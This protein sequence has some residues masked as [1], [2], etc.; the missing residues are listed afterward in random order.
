MD[1]SDI[2]I[3][4]VD[5]EPDILE[6]VEYNLKTEGYQV[7]TANNGA[8]GVKKANEKSY[9]LI[10]MDIRMPVM[11]GLDATA[12]IRS[13]DGPNKSAPIV[14]LSAHTA[15]SQIDQVQSSGMSGFFSKP[16]RLSDLT[17][18]LSNPAWADPKTFSQSHQAMSDIQKVLGSE[19]SAQI[20]SYFSEE[21]LGF[22][23]DLESH[24]LDLEE[25]TERAHKLAGSAVM[26]G[27][28]DI[29]DVSRILSQQAREGEDTTDAIDALK[30]EAQSIL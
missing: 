17:H 23:T 1:T 8:E 14:G 11:N 6:I 25:I 12:E 18:I 5:D 27:F 7:F 28:T 19:K 10:L 4:L 20:K 3:L 29:A 15:E 9:D 13:G 2:K 21:L 30:A 22:L 26:I 16:I 24:K